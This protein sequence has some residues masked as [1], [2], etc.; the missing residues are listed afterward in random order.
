MAS[1]HM[2][3]KLVP[4]E[5]N[6]RKIWLHWRPFKLLSRTVLLHARY[7]V[8]H[9][10]VATLS[11]H[12]CIHEWQNHWCKNVI[13]V[14]LGIQISV[15]SHKQCFSI[16]RNSLISAEFYLGLTV[17][18][19]TIPTKGFPLTISFHSNPAQCLQECQ[20]KSMIG[21]FT[22]LGRCDSD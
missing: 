8:G 2:T 7:G 4:Y 5:L 14:F 11:R 17:C 19:S 15:Y 20:K 12:T 9:Y 18:K 6:W 10:L 3:D 13:S 21:M 22:L 1:T 16:M